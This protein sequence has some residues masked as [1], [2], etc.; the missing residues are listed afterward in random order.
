MLPH[1]SGDDIATVIEAADT[2]QAIV[3]LLLLGFFALTWKYGREMLQLARG[4]NE[5]ANKIDSDLENES[6]VGEHG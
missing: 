6:W 5:K 4:V 3:I 2:F 1:I